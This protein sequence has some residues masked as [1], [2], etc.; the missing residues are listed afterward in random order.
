LAITPVVAD[1]RSRAELLKRAA[2]FLLLL[3]TC[4]ILQLPMTAAVYVVPGAAFIQFPWRLLAIM[5]PALIVAAVYSRMGRFRRRAAIRAGS[6]CCLDAGGV[7]LVRAA[8]E[9]KRIPIDAPAMTGVSFSF[10]GLREYEPK[11]AYAV[12]TQV[13]AIRDRWAAAGCAYRI[14][15]VPGEVLEVRLAVDCPR[16]EMLPLPL[17][18]S[19]LHMVHVSSDARGRR[20]MSLPDF[21]GICSAVVP[22]GSSTVT[23]KLPNMASLRRFGWE[24]L[25]AMWRDRQS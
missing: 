6:G 1:G 7:Y 3:I 15:S 17:Y 18:A 12:P 14:E 13:A 10:P 16:A 5:T 23:V 19:P 8:D 20:C 25:S 4:G 22:T 21:A 11:G 2:P 9:V 24:H